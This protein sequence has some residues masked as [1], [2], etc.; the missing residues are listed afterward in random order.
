MTLSGVST[1][2]GLT[3]TP[4]GTA[5]TAYRQNLFFHKN[6]MALAIVPMEIP[7]GANNVSRRTR[8]GISVRVIPVYD[9]VNDKS[10]WRLDMLYG[11][12]LI[13]PR[14]AVRVTATA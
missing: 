11:R 4:V 14:L 3:I 13:D 12:K 2:D 9:G 7:Q 10:K 1:T 5:S 6:A 8:N